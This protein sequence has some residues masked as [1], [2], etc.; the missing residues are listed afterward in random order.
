MSQYQTELWKDVTSPLRTTYSCAYD[1]GAD[2]VIQPRS[3]AS[4]A[5]RAHLPAGARTTSCSSKRLASRTDATSILTPAQI[6]TSLAA[7]TPTRSAARTTRTCRPYISTFDKTKPIIYKWR[8]NAL[9]DRTQENTTDNARLLV[10]LEGTVGN[11]DYKAGLSRADSQTKTSLT[12]G[13]AYTGRS[14]RCSAS[15]IINPWRP[16]ARP[17]PR[18]RR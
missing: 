4:T 8:A 16:A 14:I 10:G 7:A 6:S 13:Y 18:D 11:W 3:S 1:Y 9:G 15:G 17:R 5:G 2:Y 12:D